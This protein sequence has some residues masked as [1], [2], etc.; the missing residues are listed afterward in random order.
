MGTDGEAEVGTLWGSARQGL[1]R[2][3]RREWNNGGRQG[4]NML[5]S[6]PHDVHHY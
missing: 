6:W 5:L 3:A 1:L 2:N 4:L